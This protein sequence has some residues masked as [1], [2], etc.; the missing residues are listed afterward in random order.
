[1]VRNVTVGRLRRQRLNGKGRAYVD[2]A[3]I[4][5]PSPY[6]NGDLMKK[7]S[8]KK[9]K[10]LIHHVFNVMKRKDKGRSTKPAMTNSWG[11]V[12]KVK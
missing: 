4:S 6:I 3:G 1:M 9:R 12:F 5:V 7:L 10:K 11:R 2:H 8:A